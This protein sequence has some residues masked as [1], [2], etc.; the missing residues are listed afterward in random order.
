MLRPGAYLDTGSSWRNNDL[1]RNFAK[2]ARALYYD[3]EG[4][5][6]VAAASFVAYPPDIFADPAGAEGARCFHIW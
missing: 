6:R 4:E 3:A 2:V 5:C 1:S